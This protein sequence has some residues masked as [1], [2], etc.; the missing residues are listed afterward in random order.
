MYY[1]PKLKGKPR[2]REVEL[3][4]EEDVWFGGSRM[5]KGIDPRGRS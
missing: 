1:D 4:S 2:G 5:S 3:F